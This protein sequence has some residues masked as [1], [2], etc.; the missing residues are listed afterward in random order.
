[1]LTGPHAT[2]TTSLLTPPRRTRVLGWVSFWGQEWANV[3]TA[4]PVHPDNGTLVSLEAG[5]RQAAPTQSA[6][7]ADGA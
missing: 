3:S 1:M 5:E 2:Q 7:G 6:W 4:A